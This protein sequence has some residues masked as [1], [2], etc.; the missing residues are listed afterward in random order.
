[1]KRMFILQYCSLM[2]IVHCPSL[3]CSQTFPLRR[4]MQLHVTT[5]HCQ[6]QCATCLVVLTGS[7]NIPRHLITEHAHV[8]PFVCICNECNSFFETPY[9]QA[10]HACP[11]KNHLMLSQQVNS[12]IEQ[13]PSLIDL[14]GHLLLRCSS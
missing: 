7:M 2:T 6:F 12:I 1:M 8:V 11:A 9:M 13:D 14:L 3:E 10:K 4:S 5:F